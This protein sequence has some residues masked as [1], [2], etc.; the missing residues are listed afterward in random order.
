M[1]GA[2][3]IYEANFDPAVQVL[4]IQDPYFDMPGSVTYGVWTTQSS[5]FDT[6][7][8]ITQRDVFDCPPSGGNY[9]ETVTDTKHR[10]QTIYAMHFTLNDLVYEI[11]S[12]EDFSEQYNF[13]LTHSAVKAYKVIYGLSAQEHTNQ[14]TALTY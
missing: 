12:L 14:I 9:I 5:T 13:Y 1:V 7:N 11:S 10:I 4:K 8:N 2:T 3:G 6:V